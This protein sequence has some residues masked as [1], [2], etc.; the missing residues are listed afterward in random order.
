MHGMKMDK[1]EMEILL[2][3]NKIQNFIISYQAFKDSIL[4]GYSSSNHGLRH[5]TF[6]VDP[7]WL[8]LKIDFHPNPSTMQPSMRLTL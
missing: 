4:I 1:S 3:K 6:L 5:S 2:I 7:H 8:A